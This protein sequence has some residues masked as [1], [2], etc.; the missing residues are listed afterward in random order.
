VRLY[1]G[2]SNDVPP[3]CKIRSTWVTSTLSGINRYFNGARGSKTTGSV[4]KVVRSAPVP[5]AQRYRDNATSTHT[6]QMF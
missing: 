4:T 1:E 2:D 6:P 3:A 5:A